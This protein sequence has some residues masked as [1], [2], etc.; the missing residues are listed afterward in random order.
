[1]SESETDAN[2]KSN[3]PDLSTNYLIIEPKFPKEIRYSGL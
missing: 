2:W 3:S 1:M